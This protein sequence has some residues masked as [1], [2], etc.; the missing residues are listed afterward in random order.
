MLDELKQARLEKLE[1]IKNAGIN[2]Y[3]SKS[4][5]TR[6][7]AEALR[8]FDALSA[9]KDAIILAGRRCA[10][11]GRSHSPIWRTEAGDCSYFSKKTRWGKKNTASSGTSTWGIS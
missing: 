7:T 10:S 11:T 4:E 5:R 2:P 6:T 1:R 3:P 8:D 9:S